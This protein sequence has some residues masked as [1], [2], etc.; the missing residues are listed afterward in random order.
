MFDHRFTSCFN[1]VLKWASQNTL[2]KCFMWIKAISLSLRNNKQFPWKKKN[3]KIEHFHNKTNFWSYFSLNLL[4]FYVLIITEIIFC[5][6]DY[7]SI[8]RNEKVNNSSVQC[9][10]ITHFAVFSSTG[11]MGIEGTTYK[12][13]AGMIVYSLVMGWIQCNPG[14]CR[15]QGVSWTD[16]INNI[17]L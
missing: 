7:L 11:S 17:S 15:M 2:K 6:C 3:R 13:L 5:I 16:M 4:S 12:R 10:G 1:I 8:M 9:Q 14:N